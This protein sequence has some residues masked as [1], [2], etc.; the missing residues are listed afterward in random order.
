MIKKTAINLHRVPST[1][2]APRGLYN[3][4][5]TVVTVAA[6][7]PEPVE[8]LWLS[9]GISLWL[10][11]ELNG[12]QLRQ[13]SFPIT[14]FDDAPDCLVPQVVTH[15]T[16]VRVIRAVFN[17]SNVPIGN[18]SIVA[19]D[20]SNGQTCETVALQPPQPLITLIIGIHFV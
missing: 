6:G 3:T 13:P 11:C 12:G 15:S 17:S 8:P 20:G 19:I 10:V 7:D 14:A 16:N 2:S 9:Y 1:V 18:H 5:T 4:N